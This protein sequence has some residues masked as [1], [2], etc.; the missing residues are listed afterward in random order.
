MSAVARGDRSLGP[1]RCAAGSSPR[2]PGAADTGRA[3]DLFG[4]RQTQREPS[5]ARPPG[6]WP[7]ARVAAG[8]V[9]A[10]AAGAWDA[11]PT[12]RAWARAV[13]RC[14]RPN[15]APRAH[16]CGSD[17]DPD[18]L[19]PADLS[20][21]WIGVVSSFGPSAEH[22]RWGRRTRFSL[23]VIRP[24]SM[25]DIDP[26]WA[27]GRHDARGVAGVTRWAVL[28][29]PYD[30]SPWFLTALDERRHHA[31]T[32]LGFAQSFVVACSPC[33]W[34]RVATTA[35]RSRRPAHREGLRIPP[36]R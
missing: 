31:G 30:P 11:N 21:W 9:G 24:M 32:C 26:G 25:G 4:R 15:R 27:Q 29:H 22:C 20:L 8:I 10:I 16:R 23:D 34:R 7:G 3:A 33:H 1:R 12:A 14:P 36:G 28:V 5:R 19:D 6:S 2:P 35:R 17:P 18:R 13:R